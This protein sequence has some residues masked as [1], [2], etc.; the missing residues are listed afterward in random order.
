M[1]NSAILINTSRGPVINQS[2]LYKVIYTICYFLKL[3]WLNV[4]LQNY[5]AKALVQG[6]LFA[7]GLDVTVP[8]PIP[9]NHELLTLPNCTIIP[10]I[11]NTNFSTWAKF[12]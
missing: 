12:F 3:T 1:K 5:N 6:K 7:A 8:E 2:A 11:G 4:F 9:T 10:H